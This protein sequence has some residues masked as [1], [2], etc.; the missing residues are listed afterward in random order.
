MSMKY[1]TNC[2]SPLAEGARFCANCGAQVLSAQAPPQAPSQAPA[3]APQAPPQAQKPPRAAG[4]PGIP[5]ITPVIKDIFASS[6][7]GMMVMSSWT[8]TNPVKKAVEAARTVT[9]AARTV[10][11]QTEQKRRGGC[12]RFFIILL[13]IVIILLALP[14]LLGI[15]GF[16]GVGD[17][18][19][20]V[21]DALLNY[22]LN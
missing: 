18:L 21:Y 22:L 6:S 3:Q 13:I 15:I 8:G 14:S 4:K 5:S 16:G 12:L 19:Q 11:G 1:C 20:D 2:G 10:S 9:S 7:S 17:A